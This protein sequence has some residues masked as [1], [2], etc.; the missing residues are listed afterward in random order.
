MASQKGIEKWKQKKWYD[1]YAPHIFDDKIIC[2]MPAND[3]NSAVGR[4]IN[5]ALSQLTGNPAHA[6]TNVVLKV[7]EVSEGTAAKTNVAKIELLNSYIRSL[8]RRGRS[9]S[10]AILQSNSKD[11]V[12]MVAKII[13]VTSRK[14]THANIIKMRKM[15]GEYVASHFPETDSAAIV[16]SVINGSMQ[17]ELTK[18]L[19]KIV[20]INKVE[21][22]KLEV[23][24]AGASAAAA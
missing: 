4:N 22:K 8:V 5:I 9:V 24:R 19:G 12:P 21:I 18:K 2:K 15:A 13:V 3:D 1:L 11:S 16:G 6:Y 10:N 23:G 17:A 20:P 14:T 7:S